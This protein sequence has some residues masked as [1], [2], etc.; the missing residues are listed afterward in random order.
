MNITIALNRIRELSHQ[1][2][3]DFDGQHNSFHYLHDVTATA[4]KVNGKSSPCKNV[5]QP[6]F[7]SR[8]NV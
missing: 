5:Y 1:K 7:F 8:Q 3:Q 2:P 6:F 4:K